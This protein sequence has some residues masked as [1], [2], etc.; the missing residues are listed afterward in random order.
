MDLKAGEKLTVQLSVSFFD[1]CVLSDNGIIEVKYRERRY[2]DPE[3]HKC[4]PGFLCAV[5]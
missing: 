1:R 4:A 3:A 2:D 5:S